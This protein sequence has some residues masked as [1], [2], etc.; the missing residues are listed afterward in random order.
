LFAHTA[1]RLAILD[2]EDSQGVTAE[3]VICAA[4]AAAAA[5]AAISYNASQS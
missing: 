1:I 5:A 3:Q 4:A 2:K